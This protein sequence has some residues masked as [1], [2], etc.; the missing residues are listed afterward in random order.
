MKEQTI[1]WHYRTI[2]LLGQSEISETW[3][4]EDLELQDRP[5]ALEKFNLLES[6]NPEEL[7]TVRSLFDREAQILSSLGSH[8]GIPRLLDDFEYSGQFYLVHEFIP[9]HDLRQE[10]PPGKQ[11]SE[12]KVIAFLL[13]IMAILEFVQQQNFIHQN[14]Q[15]SH[16]RRHQSTGKIVLVSFGGIK[17]IA[18]VTIATATS[19]GDASR[20][21]ASRISASRISA[22]RARASRAM[23]RHGYMPLEQYRGAPQLASDI[24]AV[25]MVAIQALTGVAPEKLSKDPQ[26]GDVIWQE[27]ARSSPELAEILV[28]MVREKAIERYQN[29]SEVLRSLWKLN[30]QLNKQLNKRIPTGTRS[31]ER[32][33]LF[34]PKMTAIAILA[35]AIAISLLALL[36]RPGSRP[37]L[38]PALSLA[39]A[40]PAHSLPVYSLAISPDGQ[41]IASA[42]QDGTI[43]LW[44]LEERE[45]LHTFAGHSRAVNSVAISADGQTLASGSKDKTIKLW[46]PKTGELI[47]TLEGHS[48]SVSSVAIDPSATILASG[49]ADKTIKIW[50]LKTGELIRSLTGHTGF[51]ESVA[52]ALDGSLLASGS[53]DTTIK[54]WNLKT[55]ELMRTLPKNSWVVSSV[56]FSS[57]GK[58]LAS[59]TCGQ[60]IKL[61]D[62]HSGELLH[63]LTS[64][65]STICSIAI[66]QNGQVIIGGSSDGSIKLWDLQTGA[67]L[68]S[69]PGHDRGVLALALGPDGRAIASTSLDNT[70]KIW[71]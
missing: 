46:N 20:A 44:K 14:I 21:S 49:S 29:A 57:D 37:A 69:I 23:E 36:N 15:P 1:F 8:D 18:A 9:G 12:T 4:A 39:I 6:H 11:W 10:L 70:I 17:Q 28:K 63:S 51:V 66:G 24:Y 7:Q 5:C 67:L 19:P 58:T 34:A 61:W 52:I 16:I 30:K 33:F 40:I 60:K 55:G 45:L 2:E 50:N 48:A 26:T 54:I 25:G 59:S 38:S 35:T 71:R 41:T 3:L 53:R 56:V 68:S 32:R 27:R 22:S 43:K 64:P 31:L 13:E 47:R 42:S 62:L 65:S